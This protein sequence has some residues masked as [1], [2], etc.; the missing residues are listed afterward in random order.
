MLGIIATGLLRLFALVLRLIGNLGYYAGR[1]V[2]N[3]Y[4]LIIFPSIWLE[5][6]FLGSKRKTKKVAEELLYD[7][8]SLTEKAID[9]FND[10]VEFKEHQE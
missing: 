10:T 5:G 8:G 6:V 4:D 1:S 7:D 2:I 3:L 9:N